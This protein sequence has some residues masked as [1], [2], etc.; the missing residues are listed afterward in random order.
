MSCFLVM[1]RGLGVTETRLKMGVLLSLCK[2]SALPAH[3][4]PVMLEHCH[5][6]VCVCVCVCVGEFLKFKP[7]P[8]HHHLIFHQVVCW[9]SDFKSFI[10]YG[11]EKPINKIPPKIPGQPREHFV[12]V[13]FSLCVFLLPKL[14][15]NEKWSK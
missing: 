5:F 7:P 6:S 13:F 3:W 11:G 4:C 9:L 10:P 2:D 15:E 12:Y 1:Y 8:K 14:E